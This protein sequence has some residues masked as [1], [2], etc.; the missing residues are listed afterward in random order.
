MFKNL[1]KPFAPRRTA[2]RDYP[3]STPEKRALVRTG[4]VALFT[5]SSTPLIDKAA[6]VVGPYIVDQV[7]LKAA[8]DAYWG[9]RP[10][11]FV[12]NGNPTVQTRTTNP[13]A[14]SLGP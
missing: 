11:G 7:A 2:P 8:Q 4:F 9:P 1:F 10:T 6:F 14:G 13:V 5:G 3:I 12:P